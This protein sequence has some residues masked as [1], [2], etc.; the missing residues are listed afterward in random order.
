[1]AERIFR[2]ASCP[3]LT[4]GPKSVEPGRHEGGLR[5]VLYATD[6]TPQS[7]QAAGHAISLAQHYQTHLVMLHVMADGESHAA[8]EKRLKDLIPAEDQLK[9]APEYIV[10]KGA[11]A[12]EILRAAEERRAELIVLGVTHPGGSFSG[13]RWS[14]ASEVAGRALCPVLTVRAPIQQ[15]TVR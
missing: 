1:M 10:V 6:F 12:G 4:V 8:A 2:Q 5:R 7:M 3:V 9:P 14:V 11:A 13:R 15:I